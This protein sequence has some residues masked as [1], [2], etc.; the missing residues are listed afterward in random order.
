MCT[1]VPDNKRSEELRL[2]IADLEARQ[3][4]GATHAEGNRIEDVINIL[5][6]DFRRVLCVEWTRRIVA[7]VICLMLLCAC[8]EWMF[9][10]HVPLGACCAYGIGVPAMCF[11][12]IDQKKCIDI[13]LSDD[14]IE[15]TFFIANRSCA[16]VVCEALYAT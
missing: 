9:I 8:N 12:H 13:E 14:I 4:R 10:T 2:H 7:V 3:T 16:T 11:E 5:R 6:R 1:Q 15:A